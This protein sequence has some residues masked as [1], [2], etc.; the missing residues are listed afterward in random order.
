MKQ[1]HF[2]GSIK[3]ARSKND[4]NTMKII[5]GFHR[6]QCLMSIMKDNP[7]FDMPIDIDVYYVDDVEKCDMDLRELFIR[8]NKNLNIEQE[9]VPEIKII[10]VINKMIALWS[11]SIKTTENKA[12]YR[13]NVTKRALYEVM[14]KNNSKFKDRSSSDIFKRIVHINNMISTMPMAKL[15]GRTEPSKAKLATYER[16]KTK[17][18]FLNMDCKFALNKWIDI[19]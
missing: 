5:D 12:A 3:I 19:L 18:F 11:S 13:P 8:A 1:P 17:G 6:H 10:E 16:A 4:Y 14:K 9:D 2:I 15:F 7:Y